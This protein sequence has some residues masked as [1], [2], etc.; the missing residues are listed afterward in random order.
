MIFYQYFQEMKFLK[1]MSGKMQE[2]IKNITDS[3]NLFIE[4]LDTISNSISSCNENLNSLNQGLQVI[5]RNKT[6]QNLAKIENS[7]SVNNDD[8]I[9]ELSRINQTLTEIANKNEDSVNSTDI[10]SGLSR[11]NGTLTEIVSAKTRISHDSENIANMLLLCK[12]INS[13]LLYLAKLFNNENIIRQELARRNQQQKATEN[14]NNTVPKPEENQKIKIEQKKENEIKEVS[15]PDGDYGYIHATREMKFT[16][17]F[18]E[19][20][21]QIRYSDKSRK[22]GVY[23]LVDNDVIIDKCIRN[24]EYTDY[25]IVSGNGQQCDRQNPGIVEIIRDDQGNISKIK[26]IQECVI[27]TK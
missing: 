14:P 1:G 25:I 22:N 21:F 23:A 9:S 24:P 13:T 16:K 10:M 6:Q 19:S 20:L 3:Q 8:I 7:G 12:S 5:I 27:Y 11:I 17:N 15:M 2:F 26:V 4:K 18:Q